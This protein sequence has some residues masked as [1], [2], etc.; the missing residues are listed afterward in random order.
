MRLFTKKNKMKKRAEIC[1]SIGESSMEAVL[2]ELETS[3]ECYRFVEWRVDKLEGAENL[4]K[5][6]F[7]A[8]LKLLRENTK[9]YKLIVCYRGD[10]LVAERVARWSIGIA[11]IIDIDFFDPKLERIIREAHRNRCKV[12]VSYHDDEKMPS[13]TEIAE[14]FLKMEKTGAD[15]LKLAAMANTETDTYELLEGAA[16]YMHLRKPKS[17]IAVAMGEEGQV[18]RI[19]AGDFGSRI[20]YGYSG[21]PTAPGQIEVCKLSKYMDTYYKDK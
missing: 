9:K 17:I 5:E 3:G 4:T 20:S 16:A 1:L 2:A 12:I 8:K 14:L 7:I 6:D 21:T 10:E 15:Y 11:D 18:S 13:K 19:C